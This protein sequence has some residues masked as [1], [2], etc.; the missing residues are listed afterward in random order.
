[1]AKKSVLILGDYDHNKINCN[2]DKI[3]SFGEKKK[4][5]NSLQR[6]VTMVKKKI[7]KTGGKKKVLR[8]NSTFNRKR[9]HSTKETRN[10]QTCIKELSKQKHKNFKKTT[11]INSPQHSKL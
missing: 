7:N 6:G 10:P 11:F 9:G 2:Q 1:M 4:K 8:R 5:K 3:T